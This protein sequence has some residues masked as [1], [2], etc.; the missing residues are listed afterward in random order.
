MELQEFI[1]KTITE[2]Q[3]GVEKAIGNTKNVRGAI[4]PV[5]GTS[6]DISAKHVKEVTFDIAVTVSEQKGGKA[7]ADIKVMG[8]GVGGDM[9]KKTETSHVSRIQFS[10]PIVFPVQI[11]ESSKATEMNQ[12][13]TE[14]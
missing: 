2:I 7:G 9:S 13:M 14:P 10:I 4:N 8:M 11:V 1:A 6:D 12:G 5:W 3:A